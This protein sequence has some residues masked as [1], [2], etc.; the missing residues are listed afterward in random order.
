MSTR[1]IEDLLKEHNVL[2]EGHFLLT[3]G[4]HSKYYF[5]KF[6]IL[7]S[8]ELT[9]YFCSQL[10]KKVGEDY[11]WVIGPTTGGVIIAYE[12]ARQAGKYAGFSEPSEGGRVVG[13]G[14]A[15]EEKRVLIV[16][17]VLTTG[18]SLLETI[19]AVERKSGLI[20]DIGVLIDRS[21]KG[22]GFDYQAVYRA[23]V[24]NYQPEE[25]PLCREGIPIV[26][27]GGGKR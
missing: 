6:R 2:L 16:D 14:F 19:K 3:S 20:K 11:D 17:D 23:P 22:V 5:E 8:P 4:L 7:E 12:V 10:L 13:R 21:I 1:T 9:G 15:I 27:R 25:C 24:D 18:K 26:R